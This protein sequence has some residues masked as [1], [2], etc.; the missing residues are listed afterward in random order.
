[1]KGSERVSI[2]GGDVLVDGV[3]KLSTQELA[4]LYGQSVHNMDAGQATLGRFI[5]DSPASYEKVAAEAGD[6][7]FNLG[8]AGWEAAQAKYGLNDGQM[9]ELLNRPFLEEIIGN[10]RPV[11]FTQDPTLRPG[12]ALNKELKY[13]ESNGYEYDPSSMIATYGGK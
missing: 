2:V 10:R 8:G 3:R 7:H 12:S 1:M 5:K 4:E 13:L 9:F 6:A 11:N